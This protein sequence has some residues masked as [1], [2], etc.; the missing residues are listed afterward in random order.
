MKVFLTDYATERVHQMPP[1]FSQF[2]LWMNTGLNGEPG[3]QQPDGSSCGA[4]M[5]GVA[6]YR[7]NEWP[8]NFGGWAAP[9]LRELITITITTDDDPWPAWR[10]NAAQPPP[11]SSS[12]PVYS[13][14]VF[15]T[16]GALSGYGGV[17]HM[18]ASKRA[19]VPRF[20]PMRF[21]S[22]GDGGGRIAPAPTG[23]WW[24]APTALA[25]VAPSEATLR[26]RS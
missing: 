4:F 5:M 3:P 26:S 18:S 13:T 6:E 11:P 17:N 2:T 23:N 15:R 14:A 7:G 20:E 1:D 12:R 24:M 10:K 8:I 9:D 22:G 21:S 19:N 16:T 25:L